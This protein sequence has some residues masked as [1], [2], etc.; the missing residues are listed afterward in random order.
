MNE[1]QLCMYAFFTD[2]L[3]RESA[4]EAAR[5]ARE[6]GFEAAEILEGIRP[7]AAPLFADLFAAEQAARQIAAHGVRC[8]CYSVSVN[9][10]SNETGRTYDVPAVEA[11]KHSAD[12]A[13]ILGSP[14]LHHTLTIDYEPPVG[15]TRTVADI[16]PALVERA[17]Q[18]LL[19]CIERVNLH[20]KNADGSLILDKLT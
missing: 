17:E 19:A 5:F 7:G 12:C 4:D 14:F 10:L 18:Q 3:R 9:I 13:R 11:L 2:I 20:K 1:K 16:L 8:A 6:C 15:Q